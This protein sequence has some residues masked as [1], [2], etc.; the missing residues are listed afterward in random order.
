MAAIMV[1]DPEPRKAAN[2]FPYTN[3]RT[4]Q[5]A[6]QIGASVPSESAS[7]QS[8][9]LRR[10]ARRASRRCTLARVE[11]QIG[12]TDVVVD[13]R[14]IVVGLHP[15]VQAVGRRPESP[16]S[17]LE[18]LGQLEPRVGARRVAE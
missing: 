6:D 15:L 10:P 18:P 17:A 7:D 8:R 13:V 12:R 4:V 14:P 1:N 16:R 3:H 2:E 11:R 5:A 9:V